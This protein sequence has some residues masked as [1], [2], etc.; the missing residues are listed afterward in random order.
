[1]DGMGEI[2]WTHLT[3]A[4]TARFVLGEDSPLH[5]QATNSTAAKEQL[6]EKVDLSGELEP[7]TIVR[8]D[9]LRIGHESW[10]QLIRD[11]KSCFSLEYIQR[12]NVRMES[13]RHS[14]AEAQ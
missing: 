7:N 10:V 12:L 5:T 3:A 14:A 1:M 8:E 2:L 13:R 11:P 6:Y 4:L 9:R